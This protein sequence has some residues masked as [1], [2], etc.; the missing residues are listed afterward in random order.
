ME[1][2]IIRIH[3]A[4]QGFLPILPNS[5]KG[6]QA[7][8]NVQRSDYDHP[9][10]DLQDSSKAFSWPF[11][12]VQEA[13]EPNCPSW[14]E[15]FRRL[16]EISKLATEVTQNRVLQSAV[17]PLKTSVNKIMAQEPKFRYEDLVVVGYTAF[18]CSKCL[19]CHPLTLYWHKSS[20]VV[21]PTNHGCNTE[22]LVEVQRQK[23]NKKDVIATVSNE[24]PKLMFQVVTRWTNG[25]PLVQADEIRPI[26][27]VLHCCI[28]VDSKNWALRAVQYGLTLLSDEELADFLNLARGN[29]YG[30]FRTAKSNKIYYMRIVVPATQKA[31]ICNNFE[32]GN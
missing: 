26:P 16:A 24:L 7:R 2:H 14:L 18:I 21:I 13:S 4:P 17:N 30:I 32:F 3:H 22:T 28:L 31:Q 8:F 29:T 15:R 20:M 23:G 6:R 11:S 12:P 25:T 1:R 5:S 27:E 9:F 10:F 19:I